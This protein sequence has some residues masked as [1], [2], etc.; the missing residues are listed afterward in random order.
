HQDVFTMVVSVPSSAANGSTIRNTA[1]VTTTTTDDK[2]ASNDETATFTST[3]TT[4]ADLHVTKTGP[5]AVA[6]GT[7]I[8]YTVT[9]TNAGPSD[10]QGVTL[11]DAVPAGTTFVSAT[12]VS[13]QNPDGFSYALQSAG[14][15][16][17]F[18]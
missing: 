7:N 14:T 16:T 1:N 11:T 12:A 17:E 10:A 3:V 6:P 2:E 13:G 18:S 8:T 5:A 15:V 4:V 9:L